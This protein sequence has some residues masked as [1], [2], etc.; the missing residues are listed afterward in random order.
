[1]LWGWFWKLFKARWLLR[2]MEDSSFHRLLPFLYSQAQLVINR[3]MINWLMVD[4]LI[5]KGGEEL[6]KPF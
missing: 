1:L 3:Y 4:R 5:I 6:V 2:H